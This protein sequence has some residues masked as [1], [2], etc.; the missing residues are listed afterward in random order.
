MKSTAELEI[1]LRQIKEIARLKLI[2]AQRLDEQNG[3]GFSE[4]QYKAWNEYANAVCKHLKLYQE[5]T[6]KS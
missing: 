5:Y 6:C 1:E 3:G 4:A 2:E